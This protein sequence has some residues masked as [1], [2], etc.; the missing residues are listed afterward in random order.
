MPPLQRV[1][2]DED[3]EDEGKGIIPLEGEFIVLLSRIGI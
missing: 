1:K 3:A 2:I